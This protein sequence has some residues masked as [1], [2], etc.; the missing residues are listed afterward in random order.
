VGEARPAWKVLRVIG[1]LIEAPGFEYVKSDDVR[2]E[3]AA[4]LGEVS[5]SNAYEG[6]ARLS[7]PN[8][9]DAPAD[10]IDVPIY[11][12]DGLVRRATALQLTDEARRAAAGGDVS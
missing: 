9:E 1:N 3:F 8:G 12:V 11:S 2:D 5:T 10:E 4:Q 6:T 7:K